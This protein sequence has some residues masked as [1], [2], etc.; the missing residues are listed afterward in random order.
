MNTRPPEFANPTRSPHWSRSARAIDA[1]L[2]GCKQLERDARTAP[3]GLD[4][5]AG[6][7]AVRLERCGH[8]RHQTPLP[9]WTAK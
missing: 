4:E 1:N 6:L 5:E 8:V 7:E 3:E 9:T 2:V